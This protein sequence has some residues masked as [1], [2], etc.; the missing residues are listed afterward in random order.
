MTELEQRLRTIVTEKEEKLLPKNLKKGIT[1]LGVEGVLEEGGPLTQEEYDVCN[2]KADTILGTTSLYTE[3]EY[4]QSTG[5][6]YIDTKL[7]LTTGFKAKL[8][9]SFQNVQMGYFIGAYQG[10]PEVRSY[11][12]IYNSQFLLGTKTD[13]VASVTPVA[14]TIYEMEISTVSGNGYLNIDGATVAT[15]TTEYTF[16]TTL[17][18]YLFAVNAELALITGNKAIASLYYCEL[19]DADDNLIRN[20]IPVKDYTGKIGLFD[21]IN[22]EFFYNAGDGEFIEGGVA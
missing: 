15:S 22:N 7:A 9:I 8:K 6:Q 20:F 11:G 2:T 3:L 10:A 21:K 16:D 17:N 1:L 18:C 13:V 19:Y 14:D 4:I 12:S 5:T